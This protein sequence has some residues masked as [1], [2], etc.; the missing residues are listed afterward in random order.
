MMLAVVRVRGAIGVKKDIDDTLKML[1]LNGANSCVTLEERPEIRGMLEK[2]KDF[3]TYGEVDKETLAALLKKRLRMH[4]SNRVDEK[5]LKEVTGFDSFEN[6]AESLIGN[7]TKLKNFD[8]FQKS[9]ALSPPSG[10]FKSIKEHYPKG[11][12]G[13]RGKDINELLKK[14][15]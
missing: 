15:I 13:H 9:F 8:M 14:M 1:R 4:G 7:R 6:F 5:N 10:G 12:L 2:V 11:D 3:V